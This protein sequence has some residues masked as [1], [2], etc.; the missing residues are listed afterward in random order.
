M[1]YTEKEIELIHNK[2]YRQA[3]KHV[4]NY[5]LEFDNINAVKDLTTGLMVGTES[6]ISRLEKDVDAEHET[7]YRAYLEDQERLKSIT[8][9]QEA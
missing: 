6:A 9:R 4:M 8:E 3:L 2:G 1:T 7:E 5:I